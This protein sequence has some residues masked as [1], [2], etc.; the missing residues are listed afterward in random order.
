MT[1][2]HS[3]DLVNEPNRI[4]IPAQYSFP[5]RNSDEKHIIYEPFLINTELSGIL[6]DYIHVLKE[7]FIGL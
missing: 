4:S 1:F 2:L 3:V 6:L 7:L 5:S